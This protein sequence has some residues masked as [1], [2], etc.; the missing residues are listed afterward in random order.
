MLISMPVPGIAQLLQHIFLNLIYMDVF[1]TNDW[2]PQL[3]LSSADDF[4]EDLSDPLNHFFDE[5]GFS[6]LNAIRNLGSSLLFVMIY[7][8]VL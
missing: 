1:Q 6:S 7:V 5:N 4:D 8:A 2:L 3:F